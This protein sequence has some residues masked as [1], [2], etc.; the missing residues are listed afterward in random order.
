M[1]QITIKFLIN[2]IPNIIVISILF[3]LNLYSFWMNLIEQIRANFKQKSFEYITTTSLLNNY[4]LFVRMT[5][6]LTL[7]IHTQGQKSN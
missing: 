2:I 3:I 6:G 5:T 7:K 4:N 1:D